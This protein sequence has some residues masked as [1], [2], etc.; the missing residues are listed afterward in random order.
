MVFVGGPVPI[1]VE[2]ILGDSQ[3][4]TPHALGG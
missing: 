2:P 1:G 3:P 4:L